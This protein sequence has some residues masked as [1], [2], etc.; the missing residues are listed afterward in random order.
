MDIVL[1]NYTEEFVL[2]TLNSMMKNLDCCKCERC[3][4]DIASYALNRLPAK[5]VV[6]EKGELMTKL[7][8]FSNQFEA[9][10]MAELTVAAELVKKNPKH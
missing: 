3:R 4:L 8:E 7:C 9:E 1:K 5:Y 10:V 2:L 6:T